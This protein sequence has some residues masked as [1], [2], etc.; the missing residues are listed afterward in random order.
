MTFAQI[1]T[2]IETAEAY[3]NLFEDLFK[4]VEKD[5]GQPFNFYHIY[6]KKLVILI[7]LSDLLMSVWYL[8]N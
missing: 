2:N 8:L 5:T 3:Q 7:L 6:K 4:C 1:F